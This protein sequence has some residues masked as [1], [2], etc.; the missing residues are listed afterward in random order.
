MF[1][2]LEVRTR[3]QLFAIQ[4]NR[5]KKQHILIAYSLEE[6]KFHFHDELM[7]IVFGT[8]KGPQAQGHKY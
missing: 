8:E 2:E 3:N 5:Q 1:Y 6:S 7:C 4:V